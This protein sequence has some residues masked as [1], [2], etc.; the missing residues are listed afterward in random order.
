MPK[1]TVHFKDRVTDTY[2]EVDGERLDTAAVVVSG[3]TVTLH[4]NDVEIIDER[5]GAEGQ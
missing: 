1:L 3:S 4:L 2:V 5:S